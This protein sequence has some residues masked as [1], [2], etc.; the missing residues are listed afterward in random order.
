MIQ[1]WKNYN[2]F[3]L[4]QDVE[5]I[6][7]DNSGQNVRARQKE[8]GRSQYYQESNKCNV[9]RYYEDDF[10]LIPGLVPIEKPQGGLRLQSQ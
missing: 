9:T 4:Q 5:K 2:G 8:S 1:P 3:K 6:R 10:R 7:L